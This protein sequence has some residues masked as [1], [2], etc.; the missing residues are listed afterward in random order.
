VQH[1]LHRGKTHRYNVA[2]ISVSGMVW[3][4][5]NTVP[6]EWCYR[7]K[8]PGWACGVGVCGGGD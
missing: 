5:K 4:L 8:V 1:F 3:L 7:K 2:S 6:A